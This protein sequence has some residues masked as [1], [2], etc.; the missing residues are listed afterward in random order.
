MGPHFW[1]FY[2]FIYCIYFFHVLFFLFS[3]HNIVTLPYHC[4]L[5]NE[6]EEEE[7]VD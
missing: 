1:I 2:F 7:E 4:K 6:E 5:G 3:V